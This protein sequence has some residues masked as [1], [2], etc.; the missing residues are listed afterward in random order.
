MTKNCL[1]L[2]IFVFIT[3]SST[4]SQTRRFV[5]KVF[6][7]INFLDNVYYATAPKWNP[8][9]SN[10]DLTFDFYEPANDT[11]RFRPLVIQIFGGAFIAGNKEWVDMVAIADTL[12]HLGYAVASIDYRLG[13]NPSSQTSVMRAGYRAVQDVNS[14]I[15]FFKANYRQY[16][17]DTTHIFLLGNSA[18][19]ISGLNSVYMRE[20]ERPECSFSNLLMG[21]GDLGGVNA[22]GDFQNHTTT[23]RGI[24]AQWG[25]VNELSVI[26][27]DETT[28]LCMIHG[29]ADTTVPFDQGH[30]Y[31]MSILP[32]MY[33]SLSISKRMDTLNMDYEFYIFE[34]LGH[35]FYLEGTS[36]IIPELLDSC[37][38]IA[39]RFMAKHNEY[40]VENTPPE[41][42]SNVL[43]TISDNI[44]I[45]PNPA[46][47][48]LN[49]NTNSSLPI[50]VKVYDIAGKVL[51]NELVV[52]NKI[53]ISNF[54]KGL[55]ILEA[56]TKN[57]PIFFKFVKE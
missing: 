28:A 15:R 3:F 47:D 17:I 39:V 35:A 5:D 34:G 32:T 4:F 30:A 45:F 37:I 52:D 16:R 9:L 56:K 46:K 48:I 1:L 20:D 42:P 13:Y 54:A 40:V 19:S 38:N 50:S 6:N 11:M 55:Y 27:A 7:E 53:D 26:D 33:G 49:V 23:V 31:N 8:P 22:T 18:G 41:D 51:F 12:S 57:K 24:V 21:Q 14:A 29:S 10:Q 25:G 36:T 2:F 44:T 43:H